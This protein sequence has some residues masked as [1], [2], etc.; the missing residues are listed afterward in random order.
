MSVI[1]LR[2][3]GNY[4]SRNPFKIDDKQEAPTEPKCHLPF[5]LQTGYSYGVWI[6]AS[7]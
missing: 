4:E 5:K 6:Y 1:L 7:V 3:K 2:W